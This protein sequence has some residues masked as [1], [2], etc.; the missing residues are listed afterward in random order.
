VYAAIQAQARAGGADVVAIG[1]VADHVH[2]LTRF[3]TTLS[4]ADLVKRLKGSTS[5]LIAQEVRPGETFRWQ[6]GY[7]AFTLSKRGVPH[8]REYVLNQEEHHRFGTL[9]AELELVNAH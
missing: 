5:H 2:V 1:G 7:G 4:I 9:H 3:P 8:A 6:G